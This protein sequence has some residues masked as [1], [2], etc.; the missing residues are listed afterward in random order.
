MRRNLLTAWLAVVAGCTFQPGVAQQNLIQGDLLLLKKEYRGA[1]GMYDQA[2]RADP[3]Q[4]EAFLHRGI[5]YRGNGNFDRAIADFTQA[6]ELE[7]DNAKAYTERART[8]LAW[9]ASKADGNRL[10][11]EE[12]VS[13]ADPHGIVADLDRAVALDPALSD[14]SAL[15]VRGAVRLMQHRDA[16]A[17]QDFDRFLRRRPKVKADLED[18][19]AKWKQDRPAFDQSLLDDLCKYRPSRGSA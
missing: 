7:P 10:Q 2:V 9:V 8:R 17:Q 16:D 12:A 11:L 5:A 3:Y 18:V 15:L 13:K 4:R 1:I 6:I 19:I 14:G